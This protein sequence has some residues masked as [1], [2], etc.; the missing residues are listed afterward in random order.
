MSSSC[1]WYKLFE[2]RRLIFVRWQPYL[3]GAFWSVERIDLIDELLEMVAT[4]TPPSP[5]KDKVETKDNETMIYIKT[6]C[7]Q[8]IVLEVISTD[9]VKDVKAML[10]HK[11]PVEE[12]VESKKLRLMFQGQEL[13]DEQLLCE[14]GVQNHS[15]VY[16]RLQTGTI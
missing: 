8:R 11:L 5:T 13:S 1:A 9:T 15:T 4:A 12:R 16:Q 7:G 2:I 3:L 10:L 14:Y 6:L